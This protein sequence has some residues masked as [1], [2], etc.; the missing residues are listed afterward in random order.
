[1]SKNGEIAL[2]GITW[3]HPRGFAPLAATADLWSETRP[4]VS[5]I[6][7]KRSLQAFADVPIETLARE[8][9]LLVIDHPHV[10]SAAASGCLLP[11][12]DMVSGEELEQLT[13]RSVGRSHASYDYGGHQWALAID[14][15][16]QVSAWRP[17]LLDARPRNWVEIDELARDGK[18][19]WPLKPADAMCSFLTL[20][21]NSGTPWPS[22][23]GEEVDREACRFA[24]ETM[25]ALATKVPEDCLAMNP[26]DVLDHLTNHD[27]FAYSPLLFGYSN[28]SRRGLGRRLVMFGDLPPLGGSGPAGSILGGAGLAVSAGSKAPRE[29]VDYARWVARGDCQ[30]GVYF[31]SGGQP[32]HADAWEADDVN[33]ASND[34]FS[35]TRETLDRSW[36]RPR[37]DGFVEFQNRS[38]ATVNDYLRGSLTTAEAITRLLRAYRDA[39]S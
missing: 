26:I 11:L 3:D 38:S 10:G 17:D 5:L 27:D 15:A 12:D 14:A 24:L 39:C 34:F 7:E 31:W 16:A 6:W 25:K 33:R 28:Y 1:M 22:E 30:R 20:L 8:F 13:I 21:A 35:R 37:Y 2:R 9:D 23:K 36:L 4:G 32:A 19:L 29:A 18:V